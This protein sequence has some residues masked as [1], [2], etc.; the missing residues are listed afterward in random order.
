MSSVVVFKL[1][2][3]SLAWTV[4]EAEVPAVAK[5]RW[6]AAREPTLDKGSEEDPETEEQPEQRFGYLA[7]TK[8][9]RAKDKRKKES[10][11]KSTLS[12]RTNGSFLP[13]TLPAPAKYPKASTQAVPKKQMLSHVKQI[14]L[15]KKQSFTKTN[16]HIC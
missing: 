8:A 5:E 14:A 6:V 15:K 11:G 4:N 16:K 10:A 9:S 12:K 1:P 3:W 2:R 7:G 13:P